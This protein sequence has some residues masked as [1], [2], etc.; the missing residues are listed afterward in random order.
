M[1]VM[2]NF[3]VPPDTARFLPT[4]SEH[5]G[6]FDTAAAYGTTEELWFVEWEFKGPPWKN[7]ELYRKVS[8]HLHAEKLKTPDAGD[9]WAA[10]LPAR[11]RGGVSALDDTAAAEAAFEDALLPE[12][13]LLG[14]QTT[15]FPALVQDV[16]GG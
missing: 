14:H 8:P 11:C 10:R 7:R 1:V 5:D 16:T 2:I 6:L 13:R 3:T 4:R 15:E 9:S 12:R